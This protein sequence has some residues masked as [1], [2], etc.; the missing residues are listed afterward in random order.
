MGL[1]IGCDADGVLTDMSAFNI[2]EGIKTLK[3]QPINYDG[4]GPKDIF[5]L[6]DN[7]EFI[8]GLQVFPKYINS[9]PPRLGL[10]KVIPGI[11]SRGNELHSIT[12]R[13]FATNKG[14]LGAYSRFAFERWLKKHNINF[15]S[16]QYCSESNT[17][18][19]KLMAC[20]KLSVDVMIEDKPDVALLLAENGIKVLLFDAPYNKGFTHPNITRVHNWYE[21]DEQL[22]KLES[23]KVEVPEYVH[24]TKE[25]KEQF[26]P[27]EQ[28]QYIRSYKKYLK[29]L[30]F[31]TEAF[32]KNER[33]YKIVYNLVKIPLSIIFKTK[34]TGLENIP[35]QDGFIMASNHLNSYDQFYIGNAIGC[36]RFCGLAA[37]TIKNTM[38]GRLFSFTGEVVYVDRQNPESRK[39]SEEKLAIKIVNDT[40][41]LIF[42]E[43]TRKNKTEEG[44]KQLQLPFKLGTVSIAQKTG[45]AIIPMSLY[46]GKKKYLKIGKPQFVFPE[47]DIIKANKDLEN[48]IAKMT[49]ESMEEDQM[50]TLKRGR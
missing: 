10:T 48:T 19:E 39:E 44:R 31:N 28:A 47:D 2:R 17:P 49:L 42:P 41:A 18:I 15:K 16:I 30:D 35:Y 50:L 33:K 22:R 7:Q 14:P 20:L 23:Q 12:A 3:K 43:G 36:R 37:S 8:F 46:Y 40:P 1:I 24:K 26:T 25:E 5:G 6:T 32:K 29:S 21:V 13:K 38:R 11:I 34:V 45:S 27:E 9:E 4:Y